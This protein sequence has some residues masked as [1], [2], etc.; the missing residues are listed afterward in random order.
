MPSEQSR[1]SVDELLGQAAGFLKKYYGY[2]TFR[3]YQAEII[4]AAL[5]G[6]D[7]LVLMPTGGGKSLCYQLP[8]LLLPGTVIVI[9]PLLSLMKD[10]V[11]ALQ[12]N[13]IPAAALNSMQGDAENRSIREQ[14]LLGRFRLL[15]ISPERL[16]GDMD[17][18]LQG[19]NVSLFAIDEAHCVSQWGH[20][21]RPEYTR[22]SVIRSRFPE[23]PVMAL[24]A[25]A[26]KLTKGDIIQQ[27][28]LEDPRIFI[29]S[30]DRPNISLHVRAGYSK[31]KKIKEILSFLENHPRQSGIIYCLSRD[32]TEKVAQELVQYGIM[33]SSYHAGLSAQLREDVQNR[34]LNDEIRVV[35][36]TIAFGMGIDKSNVR[37]VIHYNMPKSMECYY[38]EIGRAGRDGL[39]ADTLLFYSLGDVVM[40]SRFA[41]DSGQS[42]VNREKLRRMQQYCESPVCRR[43]ILLSYFGEAYEHDCGNCDVCKHPPVRF[44]G[45]EIAQKALSAMVRTGEKTGFNMLIDILRGSRRFDLLSAGYDRIR[46]FG[47]GA[48]YSYHQWQGYLL[49]MLQLGYYE[50]AYN[51]HNILRVTSTGWKVLRGETVVWLCEVTEEQERPKNKRIKKEEQI[52]ESLSLEEQLFESLRLLRLKIATEEGK[53]A[54]VIFTDKVLYEM[55]EKKPVSISQLAGISGVGEAKVAKY[56]KD[57]IALIRKETGEKSAR[58]GDSLEETL[59]LLG[60]GKNLEEIASMRNLQETTVCSHVAQLIGEGRYKDWKK[61]VTPDEILSV[62][63]VSKKGNG[64]L[65]PIYEAL[66]GTL[67]YGKI[68]IIL[69]VLGLSDMF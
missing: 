35:C 29:S 21:F 3:P 15:Y 38:Q 12:A 64:E 17:F 48:A 9:S 67:S 55:A 37:W 52:K 4:R 22:L 33:A 30:F 23:V 2:D 66:D 47:A 26:D 68:R 65:K 42:T 57:F 44:D 46:T 56:G 14:A 62:A 45:T 49:Q 43:R 11:D 10:Q 34:F 69:A 63:H 54:Y 7:T 16:L 59:Y 60:Q 1:M 53:P 24:T 27:L 19:M 58:K 32:N 36:A 39:S 20:D 13:G 25:T 6:K 41:E 18:W 31:P 5:E 50:I 51:D 61:L 8:A 40:L 28:A